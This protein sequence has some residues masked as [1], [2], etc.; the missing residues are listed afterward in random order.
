TDVIGTL[1]L[2]EASEAA[3]VLLF[4]NAGSSSEYGYRTD[5][6]RETDRVEPA[7]VYAVAKAAQTHLANLFGRRG[8]MAVV[9]FRLFSV[10]G[11]WED[12]ARL[13][14]TLLRRAKAGAPL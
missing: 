2:L 9:T 12:P 1:N 11:P 6:M 13:F 14:P 8:A 10:F 5:P 4:V 7:S 3:G